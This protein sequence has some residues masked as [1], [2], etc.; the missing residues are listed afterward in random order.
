MRC[1]NRPEPVFISHSLIPPHS[2]TC[3]CFFPPTLARCPATARRSPDHR[4]T[5]RRCPRPSPSSFRA[6]STA[7]SS[8][9]TS[10]GRSPEVRH[11]WQPSAATCRLGGWSRATLRPGRSGRSAATGDHMDHRPGKYTLKSGTSF[12]L[13]KHGDLSSDDVSLSS[14]S[15]IR[16]ND[17]SLRHR[18]LSCFLWMTICQVQL[19]QDVQELRLPQKIP[20][21]P[22][23]AQALLN[24]AAT[25]QRP[26]GGPVGDVPAATAPGGDRN[27]EFTCHR[28]EV[29]ESL[30]EYYPSRCSQTKLGFNFDLQ[31]TSSGPARKLQRESER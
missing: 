2:P 6:T 9:C 11:S 27:P 5:W 18:R 16:T 4:N 13:G 30:S 15:P 7:S 1:L 20:Q 24:V 29:Q 10:L 21:A 19:G 8:S 31:C 26:H 23:Q 22:H 17:V 28:L 12:F 3:A 14:I 25:G